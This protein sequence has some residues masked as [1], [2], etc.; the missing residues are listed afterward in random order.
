MGGMIDLLKEQI[1]N[2]GME[3]R[4]TRYCNEP[5]VCDSQS[6]ITFQ[7]PS[8]ISYLARPHR[9][10][11]SASKASTP[12]LGQPSLSFPVSLIDFGYWLKVNAIGEQ[13]QQLDRLEKR[14]HILAD[15]NLTCPFLTV[16]FNDLCPDK[17]NHDEHLRS[18]LAVTGD[19]ALYTRFTC[20]VNSASQDKSASLDLEGILHF[21]LL[22]GREAD[23]AFYRL[24][25]KI[26]K[27]SGSA[28]ERWTGMEVIKGYFGKLNNEFQLRMLTRILDGVYEWVEREGD[29]YIAELRK[30]C[31]P[32][33]KR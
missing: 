30:D 3:P 11:N 15:A 25:P 29:G 9:H 1:F 4:W 18:K 17:V 21:G 19:A 14:A 5:S 12:A 23:F 20:R 31:A 13:G 8:S 24:C 10:P 2:P 32:V 33:A 27:R 6:K 22:I 26:F 28:A 16:L 7:L